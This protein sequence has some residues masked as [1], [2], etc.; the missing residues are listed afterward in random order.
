MIIF[1]VYWVKCFIKINKINFLCF[2]SLLK[3]AMRLFKITNVAC[4]IFLLDSTTLDNYQKTCFHPSTYSP[5]EKHS[6]QLL[7]TL[8]R[9]PTL[10][11]VR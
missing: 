2:F 9:Q 5:S 7:V 4:V 8:S 6:S 10:L 11:P 3:M 1:W